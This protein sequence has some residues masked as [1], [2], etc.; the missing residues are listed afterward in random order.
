MELREIEPGF[1][2][3]LLR[4]IQEGEIDPVGS[5][6]PVKVDFRLISATNRNLIEEVKAGNF[7]E[8][9]YYRLN[10][11]PLNVPPLHERREDIPALLRHFIARIAAEEGR[12]QIKGV[13]PKA[14][15][16]LCQYDWPGNIRQLENAVFRAVILC[17]GDEL[18][19]NEFPQ[20]A[21][22]TGTDLPEITAPS[23]ESLDD[24]VAAQVPL[25]NSGGTEIEGAT[26]PSGVGKL[27]LVD[28]RGDVIS[29]SQA[30][31]EIIRHAI[32][33]YEG[34]MSKVARKLGIGRST[35][36]RKLREYGLSENS[37]E[38]GAMVG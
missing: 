36:Y 30:E 16:M 15:E 25:P 13:E 14:I 18:S 24:V 35:L 27:P 4:A 29:L 20:I 26:A 5:R 12:N 23:V 17:D 10:V 11:L 2:V 38:S 31:K 21:M 32:E 28:G 9:L 3:K 19:I 34:R 22:Q 33:Y 7:R 6:K 8:D 37:E 1:Q